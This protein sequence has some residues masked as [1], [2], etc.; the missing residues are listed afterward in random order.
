VDDVGT[1][2]SYDIGWPGSQNDISIFKRS[3]IWL[4]RYRYFEDHEYLLADKGAPDFFLYLPFGL[5]NNLKKD[6]R[7]PNTQSDHLMRRISGQ[8]ESAGSVLSSTRG[9]QRPGL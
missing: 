2:T 1:I 3:N 4:E 6:T 9:I 5:T 7:S 8:E